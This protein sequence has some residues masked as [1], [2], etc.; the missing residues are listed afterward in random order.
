MALRLLVLL[1]MVLPLAPTAR[2]GEV[3][4]GMTVSCPT[5]GWEWGSDEMVQTLEVLDETGVNWISIHPYAGI[6]S[7]GR[8][9]WRP[10]DPDAP[11][12][13]IARPIAEAH[14]RGM[15]VMIKPHLAYWGSS[16]SWRGEI[17]FDD[18]EARAL[19]FAQYEAWMAN[20]AAASRGA[21]AFVVG[22]ELDKTV[23]HEAEWR[24]VIQTVRSVYEGP[25]TYAANWDAFDRVPFWDAVDI[26]GVQA[27]FPVVTGQGSGPGEVPTEAELQAGWAAIF[28]RVRAVHEATGKHVVFTEIGYDDADAAHR[29]PWASGSGANGEAI[30]EACLRAALRAIAD[31]PSVVGAF[32]W[33]WFPGEKAHGDFRMSEPRVRAVLAEAWQQP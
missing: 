31:E 1:L 30:Q 10:V 17:A 7:D 21:D 32:L 26:I 6:R 9:R 24:Q 22:T 3:V 29:E 28:D 25:L 19:F 16:F 4:K 27:Y 20:L 23:Q 14:A 18:P 5:W 2:A 33:K 8:V 11:P 15:K 13:W 12:D